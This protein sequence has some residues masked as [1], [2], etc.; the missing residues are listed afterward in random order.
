[1]ATAAPVKCARHSTGVPLAAGTTSCGTQTMAQATA[2]CCLMCA[3]EA[4]RNSYVWCMLLCITSPLLDAHRNVLCLCISLSAP[5]GCCWVSQVSEAIPWTAAGPHS[6]TVLGA[7]DW[8][9]LLAAQCSKPDEFDLFNASPPGSQDVQ[10]SSDTS[11]AA[12]SPGTGT[13]PS[14]SFQ[15]AMPSRSSPIH[16]R[17]ACQHGHWALIALWLEQ[18]C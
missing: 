8:L 17:C 7:L 15:R 1:M 16:T 10:P 18:C 5:H 3:T 12:G 13:P 6:A 4:T 9:R 2:A 14:P 11:P